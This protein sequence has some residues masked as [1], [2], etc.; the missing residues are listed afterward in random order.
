MCNRNMCRYMHIVY[1]RLF[2][3]PVHFSSVDRECAQA[4]G[5]LVGCGG[6]LRR[7]YLSSCGSC[8]FFLHVSL[9]F[10]TYYAL[11]LFSFPIASSITYLFVVPCMFPL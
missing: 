11:F 4:V 5:G 8:F 10:F 2:F 9:L 7:S 1:I 6:R 3:S